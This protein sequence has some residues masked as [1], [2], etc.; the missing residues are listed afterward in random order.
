MHRST[1]LMLLAL[2][3][4]ATPEPAASPLRPEDLATSTLAVTGDGLR[5]TQFDA[6][7]LESLGG[8]DVG[9]AHHAETHVYRCVDLHA[10]L[11]HCGHEA[12][13][14]GP[15]AD[16]RTKHAGWRKAVRATAA[17]GFDAVFS[18]AELMPEIGPSRAL[19]AWRKDGAP[20]DSQEGPLRLLV[21]T[22]KKGSR[23]IRQLVRID[24]L[25]PRDR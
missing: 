15:G 13:T 4:C 11:G 9:W 18:T 3:A 6:A 14:G 19:V 12:G 8:E 5:P 20:I 17:D 2:A 25:D 1:N 16:P 22:D 10:V 23:S 7:L 21:P 24:V